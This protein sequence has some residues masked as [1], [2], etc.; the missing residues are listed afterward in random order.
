LRDRWAS[1]YSVIITWPEASQ[2]FGDLFRGWQRIVLQIKEEEF[3]MQY[4]N[5]QKLN[6]VDLWQT[7]RASFENFAR[8]AAAPGKDEENLEQ[9]RAAHAQARNAL[10]ETLLEK[11]ARRKMVCA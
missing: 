1:G 4:L 11:P 5:P 10:A 3:V 8:Q 9:A 2:L 6:Q 7:Y